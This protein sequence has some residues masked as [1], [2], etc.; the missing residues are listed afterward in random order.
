MIKE[1]RMLNKGQAQGAGGYISGAEIRD[2]GVAR[3]AADGALMEQEQGGAA[4]LVQHWQG[5]GGHIS[6]CWRQRQHVVQ[7]PAPLTHRAVHV[8]PPC[9]AHEAVAHEHGCGGGGVVETHGACGPGGGRVPIPIPIPLC[10]RNCWPNPPVPPM[11][12]LRSS[13]SG[14]EGKGT[15]AMGDGGTWAW[16]WLGWCGAW[17]CGPFWGEE[18]TLEG[19]SET[20]AW[21]L[22]QNMKKMQ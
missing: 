13:A 11:C 21:A 17:D 14:G 15:M 19:I 2:A 9:V 3:E 7:R 8:Q 18:D 16:R 10:P 22:E 4:A 12:A 20:G 1:N 5:Q 6:R